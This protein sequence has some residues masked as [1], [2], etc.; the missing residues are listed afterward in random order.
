MT[1][2]YSYLL[3]GYGFTYFQIV[4]FFAVEDYPILG[5]TLPKIVTELHCHLW[6]CAVDYRPKYL[7]YRAMLTVETFSI[8]SNIVAESATSLLRCVMHIY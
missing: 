7:P 4:E 3:G 1:V 2:T 6:S 8:C 5:Y